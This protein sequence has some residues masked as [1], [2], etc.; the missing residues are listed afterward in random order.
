MRLTLHS[1]S[2]LRQELQAWQE[3]Y[4]GWTMPCDIEPLWQ[5][6]GGMQVR[7]RRTFIHDEMRQALHRLEHN[8]VCN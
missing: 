3:G 6:Q 8:V 1:G 5:L 4:Q 7:L 2:L